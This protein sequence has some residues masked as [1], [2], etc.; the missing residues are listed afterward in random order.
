M[1]EI[2]F[3]LGAGASAE[4]GAPV[5]AN[6]L[7]RAEEV[8]KPDPALE[9]VLSAAGSLQQVLAKA[10]FDIHNIESIFGAIEMGRLIERFPG[11]QVR[12]LDDLSEAI[13]HVIATTLEETIAFPV[14]DGQIRP[15]SSY[16]F[17]AHL[18]SL[19]N[20][21]TPR[22]SVIT[23]NYDIALDYA[24]QFQGTPPEYCIDLE[25]RGPRTPRLL[26][27]HGSLNWVR[28]DKCK[29]IVVVRPL[30]ELFQHAGFPREDAGSFT[31]NL[32]R[33]LGTYTCRNPGCTNELIR[34]LPVL[35]PP[36]WNK[37]QH[38]VHL[39]HVWKQ[40]AVELSE[41]RHIVI[42]GYS[43][44]E[45][46]SFFPHLFALGS[47]GPARLRKVTLCDPDRN[48]E[49]RFKKMLSATITLE[50]REMRFLESLQVLQVDLNLLPQQRQQ[51]T[52]HSR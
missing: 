16:E 3:I 13:N 29:K 6:F 19:L 48:V 17:L 2:V 14:K 42:C 38:H 10:Y 27:L 50:Y 11:F 7:E 32:K 23:F 1:S 41:A 34:P 9:T 21:T 40:A 15:T 52:K 45:S 51:Q 4:A 46:D 49:A 33:D 12:Q 30:F 5:M 8:L 47:V 26:K 37:T 31:W 22:A 20:E 43:L 28:C 39:K 18:L 36:T 35:V 24:L 44:P 25:T